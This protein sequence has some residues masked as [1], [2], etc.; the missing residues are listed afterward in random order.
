[1]TGGLAALSVL[2]STTA[3]LTWS[4][5]NR[6]RQTIWGE[7]A[8]VPGRWQ[9]S[10][11]ALSQTKNALVFHGANDRIFGALIVGAFAAAALVVSV[12]AARR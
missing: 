9:D 1:L 5:E 12:A 10:K 3:A 6:Y 2:A 4:T 11:L 8:R 7:L